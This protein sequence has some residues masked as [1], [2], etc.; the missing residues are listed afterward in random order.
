SVG[1]FRDLTGSSRKFVVP[2]LEYFDSVRLTRRVGDV[3][4]LVEQA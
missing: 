2:L 4:V 1:E 3:R